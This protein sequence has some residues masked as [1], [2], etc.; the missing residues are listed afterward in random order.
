MLGA[1]VKLLLL[2]LLIHTY[3]V[4]NGTACR[5]SGFPMQGQVWGILSSKFGRS[6]CRVPCVTRACAMCSA[7][8]FPRKKEN[9]AAA[10]SDNLGATSSLRRRVRDSAS[11]IF[12]SFWL[13]PPLVFL[14][15]EFFAQSMSLELQGSPLFC[16]AC[17]ATSVRCSVV[18]VWARVH[19]PWCNASCF[20]FEI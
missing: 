12:F 13:A 1:S 19:V 14:I 18:Q 8:R 10:G 9:P 15:V 17:A 5:K 16:R 3:L 7:I 4:E 20:F 6:A 2:F 11:I